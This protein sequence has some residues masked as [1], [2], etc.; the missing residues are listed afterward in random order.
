M[1]FL[2]NAFSQE[3]QFTDSWKL[4]THFGA[5]LP[6]RQIVNGIV[7][8]HTFATEFSYY[9]STLGIKHWQ[10]LYAY[11]KLG[12]SVLH[13]NLGNPSELGNAVGVYPFIELSL[14]HR[15]INWR[16]K[17]GYGF[18]YIQKPFDVKDNFKNVA[19]GSHFN[20]LI[21]A[22]MLWDIELVKRFNLSSGLSIIHYSNASFAQP[23]LGINIFSLNI[24][25][26]YSFGN[27]ADKIV[28][29]IAPAEN[30]WNKYLMT[31]FGVKEISPV[32]GPKYFVNSYSLNLLRNYSNKASYGFGVDVFYNS[33]LSD[34]IA[35]DSSLN[36]SGADNFRSGI[37]GIYAFDFGNISFLVEGGVYFF[38][39]YKKNGWIYNRFSTRYLVGEKL[40]FTL[41]LKTHFAVADF[42]E[43]GIGIK[44]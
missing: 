39:K 37:V 4:T 41:G 27:S 28:N 17:L 40:F 38:S 31:G 7:E 2:F 20:A 36:T 14:N 35:K 12:I 6:H 10:Q 23:N 19:I 9:H 18:A 5:I 13:H 30:K 34:L 15:K 22:N 32:K 43:A 1:V 29:E 44:L 42:F 11:P 8:G 3:T 33:S 16:L 26:S 24:G 25:A 21:Y